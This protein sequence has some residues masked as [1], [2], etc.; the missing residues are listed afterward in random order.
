MTAEPVPGLTA[1]EAAVILDVTSKSVHKYVCAGIIP[2]A[3]KNV[4]GGLSPGCRC[5]G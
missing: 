5:A 4:R 2:K 1:K 3:A